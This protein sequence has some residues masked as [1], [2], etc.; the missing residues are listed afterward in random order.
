MPAHM[1]AVVGLAIVVS[2]LPSVALAKR[3]AP[4][5]VSPIVHDGVEYRATHK[6]MGV[7]EA[8]DAASGRKLWE[9]RV[10]SVLINPFVERD[11]QDVFIKSLQVQDGMLLVTNER[12]Q[13]Y[14]LDLSTGHVQGAVWC[15]IPLSCVAGALALAAF[16]IWKRNL[17]PHCAPRNKSSADAGR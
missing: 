1:I 13:T 10:Y 3:A 4:K 11:V 6:R 15:W 14:K 17:G 7:V 2:L 5:P 9:T 8:F 16:Q 12:Q